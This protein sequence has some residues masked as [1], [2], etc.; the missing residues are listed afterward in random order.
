M[1]NFEDYTTST[2]QNVAIVL[3]HDRFGSRKQLTAA[4]AAARFGQSTK[5]VGFKTK[6]RSKTGN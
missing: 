2:T 3:W 4:V 5:V 6:R 1:K